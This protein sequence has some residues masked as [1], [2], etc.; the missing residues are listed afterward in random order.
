MNNPPPPGP[1]PPSKHGGQ[2]GPFDA[3]LL[4]AEDNIVGLS[5]KEFNYARACVN[6][7]DAAG[8]KKP[9]ALPE[10]M[11]RISDMC[12]CWMADCSLTVEMRCEIEDIQEELDKLGVTR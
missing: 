11:F 12:A 7:I 4:R 2:W 1:P 3:W 10:L 5:E 6:A 8:I 9:E